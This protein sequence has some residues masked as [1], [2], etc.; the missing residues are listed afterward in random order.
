MKISYVLPVYNAQNSIAQCIKTL[1]EQDIEPHEIIVINDAST[2]NTQRILNCFEGINVIQNDVRKGA[3]S[4]RNLGNAASTGEVIAVCDADYYAS[5]RS[6]AISTFFR[7]NP[8]KAVFYS[9]L[10]LRSSKNDNERWGMEAYEWGFN[11]KCP[12]SHPTVAYRKCVSDE[13]KYHEDSIETDLYEFFLLD[14]HKKG[15]LFGGCQDPLMTKIEG[16]TKRDRSEA[17]KIKQKKYEEY[18]I[19]VRL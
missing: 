6:L 13:V 19:T 1:K 2:D 17:K 16:D 12:I 18:G 15:Y 14:C 4:C 9:G 11:S 7:K 8:D 3:A 10:E 5:N